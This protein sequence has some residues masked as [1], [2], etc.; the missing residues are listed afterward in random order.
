MI[1]K[2]TILVLFSAALW[3]HNIPM[4][5]QQ[6]PKQRSLVSFVVT[7]P[8]A[9]VRW[10]KNQSYT[11]QWTKGVQSSNTV[12]I[13]LSNPAGNA[14]I[15][16]IKDPGPNTGSFQW[17]IPE[18]I[19]AGRYKIFVRVSNT[20]ISD[21]SDE[22]SIAEEMKA[23]PVDL[24]LRQVIVKKPQENRRY[25]PNAS[26][27]IEWETKIQNYVL[28]TNN[29]L[30]FDIDIYDQNGA[31][32]IFTIEERVKYDKYYLGG[33]RYRLNW[34][35]SPYAGNA[36][37]KTGYYKIKITPKLA[38]GPG[39]M[40]GFSGKI[41]LSRGIQA[42]TETL[43]P[44]IRD[45]HSR[46]VKEHDIKDHPPVPPAEMPQGTASK[47]GSARVGFLYFKKRTD[48]LFGGTWFFV[49]Y[50]FRSRITF[51]IEELRKPGRTI[52]KASLRLIVKDHSRY[53]A[54]NVTGYPAPDRCGG[55][56]YLLTAPWSGR[57]IDTPG[58]A[59]AT[60]PNQKDYTLDVTGYV[61]DWFTGSQPNHGFLLGSVD[62]SFQE[63]D[64]FRTNKCLSWYNA[65]LTIELLER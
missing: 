29:M 48:P 31:N 59:F 8:N 17:S 51:P 45:R 36:A 57:C 64:D 19:P 43:Y 1:K 20:Q 3:T 10:T 22:F 9:N 26:I 2:I 54:T 56:L 62:E 63:P 60:L 5:H 38:D 15:H 40:P 52:T 46:R 50:V 16:I 21:M 65:V 27:P 7:S 39:G 6:I 32:K 44:R 33:D 18:S 12:R 53:G 23:K 42:I 14:L 41:H 11:I 47:P 55:K 61:Q 24:S 35:W 13:L 28:K 4:S 30:Y 49:G 34:N 25:A 37:V 58:Y